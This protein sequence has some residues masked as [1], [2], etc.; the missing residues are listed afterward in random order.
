MMGKAIAFY[1]R[2][3]GGTVAIALI[4]KAL[5]AELGRRAE[6]ALKYGIHSPTQWRIQIRFGRAGLI[7]GGRSSLG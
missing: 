4:V 5:Q 2:H 7:S 6:Y 3:F 1:A